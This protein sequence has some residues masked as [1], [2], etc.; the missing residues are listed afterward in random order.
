MNSHDSQN[1][2]EWKYMDFKILGIMVIDL[3]NIL[4]LNP[5]ENTLIIKV[6]NNNPSKGEKGHWKGERGR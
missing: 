5:C 1:P 2:I 3:I 6:T 4:G